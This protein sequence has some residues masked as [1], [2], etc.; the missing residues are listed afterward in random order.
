M[1]KIS[2]QYFPFSPGIPWQIKN[3]KYIIPKLNIELWN[4]AVENRN[5]VLVGFGGLFESYLSLA[6]FEAIHGKFPKKKIYWYGDD[7]FNYL[8][9]SNGLA[10]I[11]AGPLQEEQLKD[12][13]TPFFMD[14]KDSL[15]INYLNNYIDV[16]TCYGREGYHREAAL[17]RQLFE[18]SL[19]PWST[20]YFPKLRFLQGSIEFENW[21][22]REKFYKNKPFVLIFPD[23]G[24]SKHKVNCLNWSHTQVKSLA[25]MLKQANINLVICTSNPG[26]YYGSKL[27]L[28]PNK[29]EYIFNLL[30]YAKA[31]MSQ[32][33]DFL[34]IS[35]MISKA[36]IIA[37]KQKKEFDIAKNKNYLV[38]N[39]TN[40]YLFKEILPAAAFAIIQE[41]NEN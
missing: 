21:C 18:N 1:A 10:S 13:T 36:K 37:I 4:K 11:Y 29:L 24:W 41:K 26:L 27:Y 2:T 33:I 39:K 7:S 34:L 23:K 5:I 31:T 38:N 40:L 19:L 32:D 8:V 6:I 30:P 25:A 20:S 15:Y 17:S 3:G 22:K 35:L 9:H 14:N 16:K 28:L 12:Y